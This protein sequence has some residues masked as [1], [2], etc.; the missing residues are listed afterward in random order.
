MIDMYVSVHHAVVR[1]EDDNMLLSIYYSTI[2]TLLPSKIIISHNSAHSAM[3]TNMDV[4]SCG[5]EG[6]DNIEIDTLLE[7][8]EYLEEQ[9]EKELDSFGVDMKETVE[10]AAKSTAGELEAINF[11][12]G[13]D[14]V[15]LAMYTE[16]YMECL[17]E[18]H[19]NDCFVADL[20]TLFYSLT[21]T[22]TFASF[23]EARLDHFNAEIPKSQHVLISE[24]R[25]K[26][27][28]MTI[29]LSEDDTKSKL[30]DTNLQNESS[31][32]PEDVNAFDFMSL[33][34]GKW[35]TDRAFVVWWEGLSARDEIVCSKLLEKGITHKRSHFWDSHFYAYLVGVADTGFNYD[36]VK[37]WARKKIPEEAGGDICQLRKMFFPIHISGVH[38]F[39]I[40]ADM[41]KKTIKAYDS[42][43]DDHR[44]GI[45]N[46]IFKY[47][48]YESRNF[49]SS[50]PAICRSDWEVGRPYVTTPQQDNGYDC[51]VFTIL[52]ADFL[53]LDL[54]LD[55]TNEDIRQKQVREKISLVMLERASRLY[56]GSANKKKK[57]VVRN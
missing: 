4:N 51:G 45:C 8:G 5:D 3:N 26:F 41:E 52:A 12:G 23:Q 54:P 15:D 24:Y 7:F 9:D 55:Y 10:F 2:F 49:D 11:G 39:C 46:D 6:A 13:F 31:K 56:L 30:R 53:S 14:E 34:P 37:R 38:W 50:R 36:N 25:I 57:T 42:L 27:S 1:D 47:L 18:N 20:C 28:G 29:G 22:N 48:V 43:G 33:C 32:Y 17:E 19:Q 44:T 35:L 40:V 16:G 21:D